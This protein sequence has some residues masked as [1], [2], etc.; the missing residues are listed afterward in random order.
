MRMLHNPRTCDAFTCAVENAR[1]AE[2]WEITLAELECW[3]R[4][5]VAGGLAKCNCPR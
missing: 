1:D 3:A 4:D 5:Y 2:M